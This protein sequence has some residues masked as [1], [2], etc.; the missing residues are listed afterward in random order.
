MRFATKVVLIWIALFFSAL[1]PSAQRS[2]ESY[3]EE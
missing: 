1:A 3:A 2:D